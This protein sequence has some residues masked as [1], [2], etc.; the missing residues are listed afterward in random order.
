M[1]INDSVEMKEFYFIKNYVRNLYKYTFMKIRPLLTKN[2]I[3][4]DL[5]FHK[6]II[7]QEKELNFEGFIERIK[8]DHIQFF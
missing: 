4:N 1:M 2:E 3:N 5:H 7:D 6:F 8:H